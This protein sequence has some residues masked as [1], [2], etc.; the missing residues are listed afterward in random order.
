MFLLHKE[1]W[2]LYSLPGTVVWSG[3]PQLAVLNQIEETPTLPELQYYLQI[4]KCIFIVMLS[5]NK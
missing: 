2:N 1:L 3:I 4:N 5:D